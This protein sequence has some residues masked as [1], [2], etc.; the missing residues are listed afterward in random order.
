MHA[1]RFSLRALYLYSVC[2]ITLL[3][4]IFA[5]TGTVRAGVELVWPDPYQQVE[6]ADPVSGEL[7]TNRIDQALAEESRHRWAVLNLL[8]SVS[9]LAI[10]APT[11]LYHWRRV[12]RDRAESRDESA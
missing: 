12:Q 5:I 3:I 10:A 4:N 7:V 2:L 1:D 11:Y 8:G 6:V 9:L